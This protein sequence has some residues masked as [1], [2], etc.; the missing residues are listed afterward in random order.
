MKKI[1]LLIMSLGLIYGCSKM[2]DKKTSEDAKT[3]NSEK[4]DMQTK[5][6]AGNPSDKTSGQRD[7]KAEGL[8]KDADDAIA[9][10][11]SDKSEVNRKDVIAKCLAAGNYLEFEANLPAREKYRPALKYFRKVLELDSS[12]Q[13]AAKNKKEIEDIYIQMGMPIPQ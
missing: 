6:P 13:E 1:F 5:Q 4:N 12:N 7:E 9:K 11:A 3:P 8:S 2:Q 10:Y